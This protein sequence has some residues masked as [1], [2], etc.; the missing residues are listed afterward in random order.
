MLSTQ[1][2]PLIFIL[3]IYLN[4]HQKEG[5]KDISKKTD[6]MLIITWNEKFQIGFKNNDLLN[7]I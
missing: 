5:S 7:F 3:N 6:V 2:Q 4:F 1:N